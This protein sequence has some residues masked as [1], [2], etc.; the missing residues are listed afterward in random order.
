[1]GHTAAIALGNNIFDKR[2]RN[3]ICIDGD[4]SLMHLESIVNS[5]NFCKKILNI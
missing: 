3:T 4:G 5:A 1:M 2:T